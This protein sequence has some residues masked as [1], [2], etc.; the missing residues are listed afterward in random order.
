[1][2]WVKIDD[3]F[4]RHHKAIRAGR[5]GRILFIASVCYC[6]NGLTDGFVPEGA[7]TFLA[8]E[9]GISKPKATA[10][11]LV[12]VGLWDRVAG[13]FAVHD[14]LE[15]NQSSGKVNAERD[16]ARDRMKRAR[17][18]N[19]RP[20]N[21]GTSPEVR[22]P[23]TDEIQNRTETG[24]TPPTPEELFDEFWAAY[25]KGRGSKADSLKLWG[26]LGSDERAAAIAALPAFRSGKDWTEGFHSAPEVWLRGK[27][28]ENPPDPWPVPA[29]SSQ[30]G[31]P[32]PP[33]G[34]TRQR[35][36]EYVYLRTTNRDIPDDD[37]PAVDAY[38]AAMNGHPV[39]ATP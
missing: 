35:I 15:Y 39:S 18:G 26:K 24:S 25:P 16:A 12:S 22:L 2:S 3:N 27:R 30:N 19:V 7:L 4:F 10:E 13:G 32:P 14:Y 11:V 33:P 37:I 36:D 5:D 8:A 6:G 38:I 9:T 23:D 34:F 17:S 29:G 21:D 31:K 20:N 1:M 28:W